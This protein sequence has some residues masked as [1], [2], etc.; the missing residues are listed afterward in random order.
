MNR[1]D[2]RAFANVCGFAIF[3]FFYKCA[4]NLALLLFRTFILTC[5][6]FSDSPIRFAMIGGDSSLRENP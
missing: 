1:V 3:R 4:M 6:C 5:D 2:F